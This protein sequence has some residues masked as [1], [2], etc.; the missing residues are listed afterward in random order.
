M[1]ATEFHQ[2]DEITHH[3]AGFLININESEWTQT[4]SDRRNFAKYQIQRTFSYFLRWPFLRK[5]SDD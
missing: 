5:G 2:F 1:I 3:T 4:S